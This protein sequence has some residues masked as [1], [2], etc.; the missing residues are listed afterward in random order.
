MISIRTK[1]ILSLS[2]ILMS[3]FFLINFFSYSASK[4]SVRASIIESS[5]P[6]SRDN[7]YSEIQKDLARPIFVS[8]LMANDTFVKDW[9]LGG[10]KKIPL[11]RKY[12]EQIREKYGFSTVFFVSETS[13]NYY[14]FNGIVKRISPEDDHDVWYYKF[15]NT[16][17]DYALDVDTNEAALNLLTVFINHRLTGYEGQFLGVVGV[18]LDYNRIATLLH[19]Y[20]EKYNRN[21]Y[22]VDPGGVIQ[23][24]TDKTKIET[25]SIHQIPG[26]TGIA[27]KILENIHNPALFEYDNEGRHILLTSRFVSELGWFLMV[28]QDETAAMK[29]IESTFYKNICF[30]ILITVVTLIFATLV[31]NFFQKKLEEM[32]MVDPL[33]QAFNRNEFEQRFRYMTQVNRRTNSPM[34]LILFDIDHLKTINDTMG[35]LMGDRVI[36][37]IA[38]LASRA[39]RG[40]DMLVR[41]GG[42]EFILLVQNDLEATRKVAERLRMAVASHEFD[43]ATV[44]PDVMNMISVSCGIAEYQSGQTLDEFLMRA[45][46]ALYQAKARGRNLVVT[47]K[48]LSEV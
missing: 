46:K 23:V 38:R 40:Q 27:P 2:I 33:T 17:V 9:V 1:L 28:E 41:W 35:H 16:G 31:I 43:D 19:D 47:A 11:I 42:D 22:M 24:H 36:R 21:V 12:L 15:K 45:D 14:H 29:S 6:L 48:N 32:A 25:L 30:S 39:V 7:I 4:K 8:S 26:L 20:R 34:C 13:G 3:G 10:E 18:G 37:D 44:S 5:L